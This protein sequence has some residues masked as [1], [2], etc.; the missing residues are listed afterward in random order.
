VTDDLRPDVQPLAASRLHDVESL[1]NA[2]LSHLDEQNPAAILLERVRKLLAAER[3]AL[4]VH[5]M[6]AQEDRQAAI[7]L[8]R[9]L[10]PDGLPRVPGLGFSAR[11]VTGSG[12][13]GGDW[14]DVFVL[15]DGKVG[16]VVGDVAGSGLPAAVIMGRMR[17]SLRSYVLQTSDPATAL[18]LLDRKIQYFEANAMATVLYG[19]YAPETGEL[20]VSCAGHMPPVLVTP[21]ADRGSAELLPVP[22]DLPIGVADDPERRALTITIPRGGLLCCYTDGLVERRGEHLDEGFGRL[23]RTLE[24]LPWTSPAGDPSSRAEAACATVMGSLI[25]D[26]S[27]ADDVALLMAQRSPEES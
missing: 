16:I 1:T 2:A 8:H 21:A 9:S 4:A 13:V 19:V 10:L 14:Y 25:G 27:A 22:A 12:N 3:T 18:G 11:Y 5:S 23:T 17:S 6:I 7:A 15:P 24:S 20:T 26:A